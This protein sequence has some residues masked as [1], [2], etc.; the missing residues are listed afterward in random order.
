MVSPVLGR[1]RMG[2]GGP[3]MAELRYP[4]AQINE[5]KTALTLSVGAGGR[6][7]APGDRAE[8]G[9]WRYRRNDE[10]IFLADPL[11]GASSPLDSKLAIRSASLPRRKVYHNDCIGFGAGYIFAAQKY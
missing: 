3:F 10:G 8:L 7:A 11:Y 2:I 4:G 9:L 1:G 6:Q 5:T